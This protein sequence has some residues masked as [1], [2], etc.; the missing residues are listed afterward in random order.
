VLRNRSNVTVNTVLLVVAAAGFTAQ[1][2]TGRPVLG[3]LGLLLLGVPGFVI[4]QTARPVPLSWPEVALVTLGT[5]LI[6]TI[7]VGI[8]AALSPRGLNATTAAATELVPLALAAVFVAR[9]TPHRARRA[10]I[11][12][13][14][15]PGSVLAVWAGLTLALAGFFVAARAAETQQQQTSVMQF[16]TVASA[17]GGEPVLGLRNATG[18]NLDCSITVSR[19]KLPEV[20]LDV[21]AVGDG[22]SWS[23]A[24]PARDVTDASRWQISLHCDGADGSAVQRRLFV[25]PAAS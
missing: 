25:D 24:L 2:I 5:T 17:T 4:S 20:D 22:Q 3:P 11:Q 14:V 6:T 12:I 18:A 10:R 15:R 8:V 16:W 21:G 13:R 23:G 1:L 9:S 19:P 7:L